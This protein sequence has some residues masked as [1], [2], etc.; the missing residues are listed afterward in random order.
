M[1]GASVMTPPRVC[2]APE[3]ADCPLYEQR[4]GYS[5]DE[6]LRRAI[7][8]E[9]TV[10]DMAAFVRAEPVPELPAAEV[11]DAESHSQPSEAVLSPPQAALPAP[12]PVPVPILD[13]LHKEKENI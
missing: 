9:R 10:P 5:P 12:E 1:L 8:M 7:L 11:A 4:L 13:Q 6:P 3:R 2:P